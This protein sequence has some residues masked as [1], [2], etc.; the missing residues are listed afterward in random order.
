MV[1]NDKYIGLVEMKT[2]LFLLSSLMTLTTLAT[3][4]NWR[5]NLPNNG[6]QSDVIIIRPVYTWNFCCDV[7]CAIFVFW[8]MWTSRWIM[9]VLSLGTPMAI[10][11]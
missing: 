8:C 1:N 6:R 4:Q 2:K 3:T 9:N 11:R 5:G 10:A 7:I